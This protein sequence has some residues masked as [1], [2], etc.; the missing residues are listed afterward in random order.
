MDTGRAISAFY[1]HRLLCRVFSSGGDDFVLKGGHAL[2]ARTAGAR[3]TRDIDLLAR[4]QQLDEAL[5]KLVELAAIDLDDFVRFEFAESRV[6]KA[7]D[8]YRDGVSASFVP[9]LG[10]KR[11]Q[12]ISVDLIVDETP[13][14]GVARI[15]PADRI[16]VAGLV[17]CDYLV[18]SVEPALADKVCGIL[19]MHGERPS[20]R[21]KDLVDIVTYAVTEVVEGCRLQ[22]GL[23]REAAMRRIPLGRTFSLPAAWGDSEARQYRKLCEHTE[24]PESLRNIVAAGSLAS[25]LLDPVMRGETVGLRWDPIELNW[26]ASGAV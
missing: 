3:A 19:E 26:A 9:F 11:M 6:I 24:L 13:I 15:S 7:G 10:A 14:Q 2:L 20:S 25:L 21:V 23:R 12:Q 8:D 17:V 5:R 18:Y 1:L 4:N 22:T 16:E